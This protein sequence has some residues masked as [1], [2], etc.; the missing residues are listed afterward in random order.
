M[1]TSLSAL[2][3]FALAFSLAALVPCA[4]ASGDDTAAGETTP[5][6]TSGGTG[7]AGG[8]GGAGCDPATCNAPGDVCD[9]G[10]CIHDCRRTG[11]VPCAATDV[12]NVSD[13]G[14][15]TCVAADAPCATSSAPEPCG[16]GHTCGPGS[17]CDG[18]GFC[19]PR[20]PC[21]AVDCDA[22]GTCWGVGCVCERPAGCSPAPLGAPG[23]PGTLHD[24]AF[25][26]GL[27]DLE[28]DPTCGAWGATLVSGPDFLRS[29]TPDGTPASIAGVTNLNMGEVAVLQQLAVPASGPGTRHPFEGP[30]LDVALSYICCASCG[31]QLQTTPQGVARLDTAT[32]TIP[33]VIP[34]TTITTGAGPFGASVIDTGPAGVA[35]GMDRALYVGNVDA[36]GDYVRLDLTTQTQT[37][38]ATLPSRIH[39]AAPFDALHMIVALEGGDLVLLGTQDGATKPFT[40]SDQPVTGLV[41]DF[42]DGSTY[43]ARRDGTIRVF[44]ADGNGAAFATLPEAARLSIAPDGYLY[45]LA[46]PAPFAD[47]VPHVERWQLPTTR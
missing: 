23:E 36:N 47:Q 19:W 13:D 24:P 44:D 39:A 29:M 37:V 32:S 3:A 38:V 35:Y 30:A 46:L 14:P 4:C 10:A 12:C 8:E 5:T 6:T 7:G 45:A 15:G 16:A 18:K 27:V 9:A 42:F 31:C 41:R 43:V 25:V 28:F 11:A 34:S 2:R 17:T 40:V 26:A 20:V 21:T 1:S 22:D 33:L